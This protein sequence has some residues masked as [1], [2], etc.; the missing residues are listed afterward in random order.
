[1][2][3][4][5][6]VKKERTV[7]VT[8]DGEPVKVTYLAHVITPAFLADKLSTVEIIKRAVVRWDIIDDGG[9]ELPPA[10]IADKLPT[11]FL[12]DALAAITADMKVGDDEKK[13]SSPTS[14][15]RKYTR[16]RTRG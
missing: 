4:S 2:K 5:E 14:Q 1:M 10:E 8:F 7:T 16:S 9:Q 12:I 13:V 11:S 15:R 3:F 6:I